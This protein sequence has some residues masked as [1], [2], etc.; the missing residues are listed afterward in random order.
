MSAFDENPHKKK[1]PQ[2]VPRRE[3]VGFTGRR[4]TLPVHGS[5]SVRAE[6]S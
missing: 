5:L 1:M 3:L 4:V 2:G 6:F